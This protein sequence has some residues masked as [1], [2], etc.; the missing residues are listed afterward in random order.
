MWRLV[1]RTF[2]DRWPLFMGTMLAVTVGV[3]LVHAGMTVVLGTEQVPAG[4][5][6]AQMEAFRQAAS[7]ANTLTGMSVLLSTFLTVFVVASTLGFAAEQR[8]SEL[9]VLRLTG[10]TAR[11]LRGVI[12]LEALLAALIGSGAGALLG[13]ALAQVQRLILVRLGTLP[14]DFPLPF[15]P[16]ILL[17]DLLVAGS[18]CFFGA[19]GTA[20]QATRVRPLAAIR[21]NEERQSPMTLRRWVTAS[22]AL[23]L[24]AVQ[25]YFSAVAS[26]M[27]IPLLLGLGIIITASFAMNNLAP[28]LVPVVARLLAS[29]ARRWPVTDL[30][31]SNLR[32]AVTRTTACAAPMIV[33]VSLV[34]GLQGILDTQT[35]AGA[36]ETA[37]LMRAD[38]IASGERIDLAVVRTTPGVALAAPETVVPLNVKLQRGTRSPMGQEPWSPS[39]LLR[40]VRPVCSVLLRAMW[41]TSAPVTSCS[42]RVWS[43]RCCVITMT[44][45]P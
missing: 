39:I 6:P 7:G 36:M 22:F 26:G 34:M 44:A 8:R 5:T 43:A 41:S 40:F 23:L 16:A 15:Q 21:R 25:V 32:D 31:V 17:L 30:A 35:K 42:A 20:R 13:V 38:L 10:V 28:L 1:W 18:V 2:S 3:A 27:L 29:P 14:A 12:L 9:A 11:Q 4:L 45:L 37:K 19:W 33:L 24:T